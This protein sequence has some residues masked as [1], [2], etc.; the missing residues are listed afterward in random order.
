MDK[1]NEQNP[2]HFEN[3]VNSNKKNMMVPTYLMNNKKEDNTKKSESVIRTKKFRVKLIC[4]L[5]QWKYMVA[6]TTVE[7]YLSLFG[8]VVDQLIN[9][10][11]F[12]SILTTLEREFSEET[13]KVLEINFNKRKFIYYRKDYFLNQL[14]IEEIPFSY[15]GIFY[16]GDTI[17]TVI[18]IP[19]IPNDILEFWNAQIKEAQEGIL[20]KIFEGWKIDMDKIL[21]VNRL[22][23]QRLMR[24]K[25]NYSPLSK[26]VFGFIC[27]KLANYYHLLEKSGIEFLEEDQFYS[28]KNIWEW[29]TMNSINI[30]TKIKSLFE[31]VGVQ[32][33]ID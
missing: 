29:N 25:S 31:K 24:I 16:E 32:V 7:D 19:K 4:V 27:S 15:I 11:H 5:P 22:Y 17:F 18:Y 28:A 12:S 8:G 3:S 23:H 20:K 14:L 30:K 9:K 2:N 6:K 1:N 10:N 21:E 33:Y 13:T 26:Q